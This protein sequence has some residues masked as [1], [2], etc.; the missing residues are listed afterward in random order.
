M[1]KLLDLRDEKEKARKAT[2]AAA[3]CADKSSCANGIVELAWEDQRAAS[4]LGEGPPPACRRARCAWEETERGGK[5]RDWRKGR[6]L[7]RSVFWIDGGRDSLG[8]SD[9]IKG[10][11]VKN[12]SEECGMALQQG[13]HVS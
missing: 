6:G 1:F 13:V 2:G 10:R 4:S 5:E 11:K 12:E 8:R 3:N 7:T 9:Q